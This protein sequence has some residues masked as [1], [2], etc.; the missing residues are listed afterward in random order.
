[1]LCEALLY[2]LKRGLVCCLLLVLLGRR[3]MLV[4][5]LD[6]L[7]IITARFSVCAIL[8]VCEGVSSTV[9]VVRRGIRVRCILLGSVTLPSRLS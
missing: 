7:V 5:W 6:L 4:G 8:R 1:M 2:G 9:A 3:R